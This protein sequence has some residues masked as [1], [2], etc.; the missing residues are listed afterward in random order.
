MNTYRTLNTATAGNPSLITQ[1]PSRVDFVEIAVFSV[2]LGLKLV[3][4]G[5]FWRFLSCFI[6]AGHEGCFSKEIFFRRNEKRIEAVSCPVPLFWGAFSLE[7]K[8]HF[9]KRIAPSPSPTPL[10]FGY[11]HDKPIKGEGRGRIAAPC[12]RSTAQGERGK[13]G[14]RVSLD[15]AW[16][17]PDP[18]LRYGFP[19]SGG[20]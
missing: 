12:A 14:G 13:R 18:P 10:R 2:V 7:L 8:A 1:N 5:L 19:A 4:L 6:E 15:S 20:E 3:V 16:D 11:A 17:K 9:N